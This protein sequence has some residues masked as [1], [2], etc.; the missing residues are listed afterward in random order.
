MGMKR[1]GVQ[2]PQPSA[3]RLAGI[4]KPAPKRKLVIEEAPTS[5]RDNT[6]FVTNLGMS[7]ASSMR[8]QS[9]PNAGPAGSKRKIG[10][11]TM[12][13][14]VVTKSQAQPSKTQTYRGKLSDVKCNSCGRKPDAWFKKCKCEKKFI[15]IGL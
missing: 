12:S 6:T 7:G 11:P 10:A 5:G 1:Q 3:S 15:R 13:M 2:P 9:P 8:R 4:P 14:H